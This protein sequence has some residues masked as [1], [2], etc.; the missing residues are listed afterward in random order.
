[1]PPRGRVGLVVALDAGSFAKIE[2]AA[3]ISFG[4]Q[5]GERLHFF[6]YDGF[7]EHLQ[8]IV[9]AAPATEP[10][11]EKPVTHR[12]WTVKTT[13]VHISPEEAKEREAAAAS[14]LAKSAS[15][16]SRGTAPPQ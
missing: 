15:R 2:A 11:A 9:L 16:T 5:H 3:R 7:N 8:N 13:T 6:L 4:D 14:I 10:E 1:M 12:G